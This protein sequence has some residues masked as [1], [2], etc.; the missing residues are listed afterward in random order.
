MEKPHNSKRF[1]AHWVIVEALKE[2]KAAIQQMVKP[3]KEQAQMAR[4]SGNYEKWYELRERIYYIYK[5][6]DIISISKEITHHC[7]QME[8]YHLKA[9]TPRPGGEQLTSQIE[10]NNV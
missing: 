9:E 4:K 3:I 1:R 8:G 2:R 5:N 6:Q 10:R 7:R